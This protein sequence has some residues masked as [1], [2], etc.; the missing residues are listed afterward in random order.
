MKYYSIAVYLFSVHRHNEVHNRV[1][2]SLVYMLSHG[3]K[4]DQKI[5]AQI[6]NQ[7]QLS[8]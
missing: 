3:G 6:I 4:A 7:N 8:V 1:R 5:A 2:V